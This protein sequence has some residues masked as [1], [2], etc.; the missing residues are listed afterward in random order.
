MCIRDRHE[1][2]R[3][4]PANAFLRYREIPVEVDARG[5]RVLV[6][7]REAPEVLDQDA[8]RLAGARPFDDADLPRDGGAD[9]REALRNT[10]REP[11]ET[12]EV[13]VGKGAAERRAIDGDVEN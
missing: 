13:D 10:R 9:G 11:R 2:V 7:G 4:V 12:I 6:R 1:R 8:E 3:S 5:L